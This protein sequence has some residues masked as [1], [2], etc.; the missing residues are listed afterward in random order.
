MSIRLE[1]SVFFC[2]NILSLTSTF[3]IMF[4]KKTFVVFF[5]LFLSFGYS[6]V[7]S[8]GVKYKRNTD[9]SV[10]F[11]Y[12]ND[13]PGSVYVVLK[14]SDL[15]NASHGTVK[16]TITGYIG[17]IVTLRPNRAN[18]N[19]GFAYS[20]R[21]I[22]GNANAKPDTAFIYALPFKE[23]KTVKVK[24]MNYLGTR[25][26]DTGPKNWRSFQFL[27]QPNDTVY[28]V[29][30]GMVVRIIDGNHSDEAKEYS[31]NSKSNYV[32]IEHEDGTLA[33]YDVLKD[34]SFFVKVGDVVYPSI[35]LAIAGTY[36]LEEN[37]QL[38]L[39]IYYLDGIVKEID[40]EDKSKEE[41]GNKTHMYAYID[42]LFSVFGN[43]GLK[44]V[45]NESYK[46]VCNDALKE[47]EMSKREK[48]RLNKK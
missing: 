1:L 44:L 37:S 25:F 40:F 41:F 17:E 9:K 42:P 45:A 8:K 28:A 4:A 46:S 16:K 2:R 48:K 21:T 32:L 6:Q 5:L 26:G 19:I 7:K 3:F 34:N 36:D 30:K 18:E 11:R 27:A 39:T 38:R 33:K 43:E 31:Y 15:T 23:G 22:L 29:R 47:A 24:N 20:Y 12:E 35:P 10:T 13:I 14:F